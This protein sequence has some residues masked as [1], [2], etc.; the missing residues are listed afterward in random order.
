[1]TH[2]DRAGV[3]DFRQQR[4]GIGDGEL[5]MFGCDAIGKRARRLEVLDQDQRAAT[6]ERCCDD[7]PTRHRRK[8]TLRARRDGI[9]QRG[10]RRDEDRLRELVVLGLREEIHRHPIRIRGAVGD[11]EN[12]RCAGHHVDANGAEH[13]PLR[14]GDIGIAGSADL[15]DGRD[16]RRAVGE[17][18]DRLRA[19]AVRSALRSASASES[20]ARAI[21]APLISSSATDFAWM[22]SKRAV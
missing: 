13:T 18:G 14:C 21:S 10:I 11:D 1:M 17:R 4:S 6:A 19:A 9:E 8:L 15:V 16:A 3:A 7:R 12:L 22:P 2:E 20:N 5:Q